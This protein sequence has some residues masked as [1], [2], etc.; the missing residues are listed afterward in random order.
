VAFISRCGQVVVVE[1]HFDEVGLVGKTIQLAHSAE[2]E[3][4]V[5]VVDAR[6]NPC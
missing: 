2:A 5:G 4:N 3:E 1:A 6:S